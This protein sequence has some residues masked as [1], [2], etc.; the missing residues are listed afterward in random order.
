MY[1]ECVRKRAVDFQVDA[2]VPRDFLEANGS[3]RPKTVW[4][5]PINQKSHGGVQSRRDDIVGMVRAAP[6][7]DLGL[8]VEPFS[9]SWLGSSTSISHALAGLD[10]TEAWR[11]QATL[12]EQAGTPNPQV[13]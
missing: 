8:G 12:T 7:R 2:K 5:R 9:L 1:F 10:K 11:L 6:P 13:S 3:E 4:R